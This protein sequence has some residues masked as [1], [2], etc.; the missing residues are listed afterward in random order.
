MLEKKPLLWCSKYDNQ[1]YTF[2]AG[3]LQPKVAWSTEGSVLALQLQ[4]LDAEIQL[5]FVWSFPFLSVFVSIS[6]GF[7]QLHVSETC[8]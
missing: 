5:L 2:M 1:N 4:G 7:L 3:K 6:S 8:W